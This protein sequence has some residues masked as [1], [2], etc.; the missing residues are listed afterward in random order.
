[1]TTE[2]I[3]LVMMYTGVALIALTAI[4]AYSELR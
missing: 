4:V 2:T 1:L 3:G